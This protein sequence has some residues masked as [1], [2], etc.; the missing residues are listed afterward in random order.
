MIIIIIII[1]I[2]GPF[3]HALICALARKTNILGVP[4][5]LVFLSCRSAVRWQMLKCSGLRNCCLSQCD[6]GPWGHGSSTSFF[7]P[8]FSVRGR[9]APGLGSHVTEW[10]CSFR[11][12]MLRWWM[13]SVHW[14]EGGEAGEWEQGGIPKSPR[15]KPRERLGWWSRT[16]R[17]PLSGGLCSRRFSFSVCRAGGRPGWH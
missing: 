10:S 14:E 15:M 11:Q 7:L 4:N 3:S 1:K 9:P 5:M 6:P 17:T 16:P 2:E 12:L 13:A 8:V